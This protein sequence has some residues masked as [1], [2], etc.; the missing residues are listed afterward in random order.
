MWF[1]LV[2]VVLVVLGIA[3][4]VFAGGIFTISLV[5]LALIV[6]LSGLGYSLISRRPREGGRHGRRE[7]APASAAPRHRARPDLAERLADER[8][9]RQ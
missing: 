3:G 9:I 5:P 4:G 8:R 6:L 1:Y 7:P 2:V